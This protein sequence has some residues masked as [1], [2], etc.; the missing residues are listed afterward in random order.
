MLLGSVPHGHPPARG[1]ADVLLTKILAMLCGRNQPM[2]LPW[3]SWAGRGAQPQQGAALE[4]GESH[5]DLWE[6]REVGKVLQSIPLLQMLGAGSEAG[7]R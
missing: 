6:M 1:T 5:R 4:W 3:L 7:E 2:L